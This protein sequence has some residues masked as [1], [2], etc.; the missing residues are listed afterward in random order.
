MKNLNS[1]LIGITVFMVMVLMSNRLFAQCDKYVKTFQMSNDQKII[2]SVLTSDGHIVMTGYEY[3][4]VNNRK[5]LFLMKLN[6]NGDVINSKVFNKWNATQD[7]IGYSIIETSD[8]GYAVTGAIG[9]SNDKTGLLIAKF[10]P[11]FNPVWIN[12]LHRQDWNY[13]LLGNCLIE[14]QSDNNK[15]VVT[16]MLYRNLKAEILIAKFDH[17]GSLIES[18]TGTLYS[19]V[20][21][22]WG[23]SIVKK[24]NSFIVGGTMRTALD[25]EYPLI[26]KM[27]NSLVIERA[28]TFDSSVTDNA[29]VLSVVPVSSNSL[30]FTGQYE[31][32]SIVC[33]YNF[34][35]NYA[36]WSRKL[37]AN[38]SGHSIIK[39]ADDDVVIT[40]ASSGKVLVTKFNSDNG[41]MVFGL[42]HG[43]TGYEIGHSIFEDEEQNLHIHGFTSSWGSQDQDPLS[44]K[45]TS[46][47]L[48]CLWSPAIIAPE[49]W[50]PII[51]NRFLAKAP[52]AF[53]SFNPVTDIVAIDPSC[54]SNTV[55]CTSIAPIAFIDSIIPNP[56]FVDDL[57]SFYGHGISN[58]GGIMNYEW[59]Y[60]TDGFKN[61]IFCTNQNCEYSFTTPGEYLI[62]FRVQSDY[63][64][65]SAF[66][67]MSINVVQRPLAY[68]NKIAP[69]PAMTGQTVSFY[70][71]GKSFDGLDIEKYFWSATDT[72]FGFGTSI[73][74]QQ[75]IE[76]VFDNPGI[77]SIM[78]RVMDSN[79][80]WSLPVYALLQIHQHPKAF[81]DNIE[82]NPANIRENVHFSG[83]GEDDGI[84]TKYEWTINLST[85]FYCRTF[86]LQNFTT[87]FKESGKYFVSLRV[88]DNHGY[89]SEPV[90]EILSINKDSETSDLKKYSNK[91]ESDL[92]D[93]IKSRINETFHIQ[94]RIYPNPTIGLFTI[95][96]VQK[97]AMVNVFNTFGVSV[98]GNELSLPAQI[99]LTNRPKG[100]YFIRIETDSE[101]LFEKIII[102]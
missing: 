35:D 58:V 46:N 36:E 63:G 49:V 60:S 45:C 69:N 65:W 48:T 26:V 24:G 80:I 77:F 33:R 74:D 31:N 15:I 64:L 62:S 51:N 7:L 55:C 9:Y 16:G 89:W 68:I 96:G 81:I 39:A 91:S 5:D 54:I 25:K 72:G 95:E 6:G 78:L 28:V 67:T 12:Q 83:Y 20:F 93:E 102:N 82:P 27:T 14:D 29:K 56:A 1:K 17:Y 13:S 19:S 43:G 92:L 3:S 75:N 52:A 90:Y 99:D 50:E 10:D 37:H 4:V 22:V 2:S 88:Q 53:L 38:T 98:F 101:T 97:K 34:N 11:D 100:I 73:G 18:E 85:G 23:Y 87:S 76:H 47:G 94:A 57:I 8:G 21:G 84:I 61:Q 44:I 41:D 79:G 30:I 70:G 66:D 71:D 42:S 32:N 86:D 59:S 40:G